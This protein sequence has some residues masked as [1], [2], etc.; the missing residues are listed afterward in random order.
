MA[1]SFLPLAH[2]NKEVVL[3]AHFNTPGNRLVTGS[4]DHRLR[5]FDEKDNDWIL[6]EEWRAHSAEV[7][8]VSVS[9][10]F[11]PFNVS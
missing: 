7:T 2:A 5:V 1:E 8:E 6:I 9:L 4:A 11:P 3:T 10:G